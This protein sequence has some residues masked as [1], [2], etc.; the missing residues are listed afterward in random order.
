[1]L[2]IRGG[3]VLTI[4][5]DTIHGGTI[6]IEGGKIRGMGK[7]IPIPQGIKIIDARG[8]V[9]MPGLVDAHTH[10]G[11]YEQGLGFEG[12]DGNESIDP[13]TPH[14]RSI[15]GINNL[16]VAVE[17]TLKGGVTTA[18]VVP[19]SANVVGGQGAVIKTWGKSVDDMVILEPAGLKVAFG[20]NPRRVYGSKGKAPYSRMGT[21]AILRE[22]LVK[23]LN[24]IDKIEK[25]A[26]DPDKALERDLKMEPVVKVL[27]K[28]MP[29]LAHAHRADDILTAIRIAE[30]FGVDIVIQHGTEGPK[31]ADILAEKGISVITGPTFGVASK[32]E[33]KDKSFK[34]PA[35]LT[36][37]GVKVAIMSDHPVV[38]SKYLLLY[39]AMAVKEGMEYQDALKAITINPAQ[40]IGVG[41]RVGSLQKGKDAD[42]LILS[43]SPLDIM[44]NIEMVMVNG[45]IVANSKNN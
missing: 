45:Q 44:T 39:A 37:A 34:D 12:E 23:G 7:D 32:I 4:T 13:V 8:K 38:P 27:K 15:D 1:M 17:E 5:G 14:V 21:A 24:Y 3:E 22:T 42:I 40:I 9:V 29:L 2:A 30:E 43:G 35:T 19:G 41:H 33:N 26:K 16:D 20:E 6:L 31:I 25:S 36:K 10:L 28:E 18:M 11:L